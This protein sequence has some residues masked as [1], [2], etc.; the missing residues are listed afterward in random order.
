MHRTELTV[1]LILE[2]ADS[3]YQRTGNWPNVYSGRVWEP[4][5]E[6]WRNI[7]CSL[8]RG[9]RGLRRGQSLAMILAKHRGVRNRKSLPAFSI[10][11]ILKWADTFHQQNGRWPRRN[12]GVIPGTNGETWAAV[13]TA[14]F[15]G[16]RGLPGKSSLARLLAVKRSARNRKLRPVLTIRQILAWPDRHRRQI[17]HWPTERSGTIEGTNDTWSAIAQAL[18]KGL[19]GL[20]R[21]SLPKILQ[22]YRQVPLHQ[23]R[24]K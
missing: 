7:D 4:V 5:S 14:L 6:T 24:T 3:H 13:S 16:Q 10:R 9:Q 12:D 15:Q 23:R 18:V 19:R 1:A 20:R 8:R 22:R 21:S 17:G 2:W 11:Q